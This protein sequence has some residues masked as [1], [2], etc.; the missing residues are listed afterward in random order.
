[1]EGL[2]ST[3]PTPSS[4]VSGQKNIF[5]FI[6]TNELVFILIIKLR[7]KIA[8]QYFVVNVFLHAQLQTLWHKC[9][10]PELFTPFPSC[11]CVFV[12]F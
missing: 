5:F 9:A 3:G 12:S 7:I 4:L 6:S 1:M 8:R 2:L 10:L 11:L